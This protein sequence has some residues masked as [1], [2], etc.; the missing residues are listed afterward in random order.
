MVS[1]LLWMRQSPRQR[2]ITEHRQL[3]RSRGVQVSLHVRPEARQDETRLEAVCYRLPWTEKTTPSEWVLHR[4][5]ERGWNSDFS[6]WNWAIHQAQ[7]RCNNVLGEALQDMPSG[8]KAVVSD[9]RGLALFWDERGTRSDCEKVCDLVL[10][11]RNGLQQ[12]CC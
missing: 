1:P 3:A 4:Y 6:G 10:R 9:K 2:L 11:L 8:V 12:I 7:D 5:S